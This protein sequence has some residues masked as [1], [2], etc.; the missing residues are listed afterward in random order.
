MQTL[1]GFAAGF[2]TA[3][4]LAM[5]VGFFGTALLRLFGLGARLAERLGFAGPFGA[6]PSD[7]A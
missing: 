1:I 3:L 6:S 4:L 5:F 7:N 2:A